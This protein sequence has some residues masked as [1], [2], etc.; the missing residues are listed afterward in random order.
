[1]II[2]TKAQLDEIRKLITDHHLA[3]FVNALGGSDIVSKQVLE[4][5]KSLGLVVDP[6]DMLVG[7]ALLFGHLVDELKKEGRDVQS[8]GY[9]EFKHL[10]SKKRGPDPL[11]PRE[12]ATLKAA[13]ANVYTHLKGL[14][15]TIDAK[16]G[17]VI[18]E[19]DKKL[20]ATLETKVKQKI[21]L[22][23]EKRKTIKQIALKLGE[24]TGDYARDWTRIAYTESNNCFM[25]GKVA[26]IKSRAPL[27][28]EPMVYKITRHDACDE[29]KRAYT[30]K[31]GV[32]PKVFKLSEM[33]AFGT[34][35]GRKHGDRKAVTGSQHPWCSCVLQELQ[36][37]FGFDSK[38]EL[39]YEGINE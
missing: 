14:G 13:R 22:G 6:K 28:Y 16:T 27:G 8:M 12:K 35:V 30:E 11:S 1:M 34:N 36:P 37:G 7:D 10:A 23:L 38:G 25:E 15:N 39:T 18:I 3:F 33:L 32:T 24:E 31:D 19:G 29:C 26:E 21:A 20:R 17:E 2:L 4:R 9:D 5:L